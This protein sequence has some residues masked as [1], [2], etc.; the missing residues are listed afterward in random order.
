MFFKPDAFP[1]RTTTP[2]D[3]TL[4][5]SSSPS[6]SSTSTVI[7]SKP[8]PSLPTPAASVLSLKARCCFNISCA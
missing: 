4:S 5:A 7:D 8:A 1:L 3:A 2:F 6:R